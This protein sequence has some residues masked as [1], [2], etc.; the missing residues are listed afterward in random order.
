MNLTALIF[1]H[2]LILFVAI[3]PLSHHT[4]WSHESH[5]NL[6]HWEIASADPDRIVLTFNGD[7]S[8]CRAVSWRTSKDV[9]TGVAEIAVALGEPGM[10]ETAQRI[11]ATTTPFEMNRYFKNTQG[12]VHYHCA[13]FSGLQPDT[14]YAYR[15]GDGKEHWSEWIQFRTAKAGPSPFSFLYF[16]DA[17]NDVL[18][19]WSR[20]I[21]MSYQT[22]PDASFAIHAG[23]LVN[24]AHSDQE[25]GEWFK[26]GSFLHAQWTTVPVLGNHEFEPF[27]KEQDPTRLVS[28][29]WRPQFSLP[30]ED[31][32]PENLHETV[33]SFSYQGAQI[34]VL[35]SNESI[36]A[37]TDYLE[38][39]LKEIGYQWRIVTYHHSVFS[40]RNRTNTET[41]LIREHWVPL[42]HQYG[43]DLV[44][45]GH[46]H[47]YSRGTKSAATQDEVETS[48]SPV[49]Y[50]TSVS[51]PKQYEINRPAIR[52]YENEYQVTTDRVAE[53]T[54]FFQVIHVD[55]DRLTYRAYTATGELYDTFHI[56]KNHQ[57]GSKTIASD[58]PSVNERNFTNTIGESHDQVKARRKLEQ[59]KKS[60]K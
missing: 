20:V 19:T 14:L 1:R 12:T 60:N 37:Q 17:Q 55:T 34:I 49:V 15:V 32:L 31:S 29:L 43:V 52:G 3:S 16:G 25:W 11:P 6:R 5:Q 48:P 10:F 8:T 57:T 18:S 46:D 2:S 21:R 47:A 9:S 35:N 39:R 45:Q 59:Q 22:A 27:N 4:V 13:V 42:F 23:D 30:I 56:V 24:R 44:L 36:E 33:F 58:P 26:A 50:V 38:A 28:I 7:P 40:P 54:Q 51:G 53:N 41:D